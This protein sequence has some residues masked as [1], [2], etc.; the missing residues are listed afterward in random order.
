MG[1]V[2]ALEAV[3]RALG[4]EVLLPPIAAC[5]GFAGDRGF[6]RPELTASALAPE[7]A[8]LAGAAP[9]LCVSSNRTCEIGLERAT[10]LPWKPLAVALE[11]AT[12]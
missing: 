1:Q 11:E 3:A 8:R 5:C 7:A 2:P 9:D 12:R 10:G 6:L 4:E